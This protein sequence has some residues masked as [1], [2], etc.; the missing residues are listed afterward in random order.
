M[1]GFEKG[2]LQ[3]LTGQ[4]CSSGET[5]DASADHDH[6]LVGLHDGMLAVQRVG[7]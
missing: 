2:G 6:I 4:Q 7:P 3:A 1:V 5:G